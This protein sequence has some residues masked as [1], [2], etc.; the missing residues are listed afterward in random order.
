MMGNASGVIS[1]K[2]KMRNVRHI[3]SG[4]GTMTMGIANDGLGNML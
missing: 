3:M 1:L 2:S 4:T